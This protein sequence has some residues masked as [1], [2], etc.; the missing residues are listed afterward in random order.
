MSF[1]VSALEPLEGGIG[2]TEK[3]VATSND[4]AMKELVS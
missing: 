4:E 3:R 1:E 2:V